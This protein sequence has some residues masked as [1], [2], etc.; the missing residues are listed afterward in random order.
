MSC[1][2][3]NAHTNPSRSQG[4]SG[5]PLGLR[6]GLLA[7]RLLLPLW[8][9]GAVLAL[10]ACSPASEISSPLGSEEKPSV[11]LRGSELVRYTPDGKLVW[12]LR[13]PSLA[14][15]EDKQQT[16][17][18]DV[19]V[20]FFDAQGR[21]A[22]LVTAWELVFFH[23]TGDFV[24]RRGIAARDPKG[25]RFQTEEARWAEREG[26]LRGDGPVDV[27]RPDVK[28]SGSGFEYF[29]QEGKLIVH[30]AQLKLFLPLSSPKQ[31]KSPVPN[32]G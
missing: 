8:L 1:A 21:E 12:T 16:L 2:L 22:L 29:P 30:N 23:D 32:D 3:P 4:R 11:K 18:Q 7:P 25:L 27:E 15:Y 26:V 14:Y 13:S 10:T 31:E 6:L 9:A 5:F 28:L 24:L 20:R 19:E 17:A